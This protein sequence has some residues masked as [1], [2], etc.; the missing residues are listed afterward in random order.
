MK[1]KAF[2]FLL[3]A[4]PLAGV[5]FSSTSVGA[6]P[7][8]VGA[9]TSYIDVASSL[10]SL[11]YESYYMF[12][13]YAEENGTPYMYLMAYNGYGFFARVP[14]LSKSDANHPC[15]ISET[16]FATSCLSAI[17]LAHQ[18]STSGTDF[19]FSFVT[20]IS[21]LY[22][23]PTS[24]E[25][26]G[27]TAS[28]TNVTPSV[29][30]DATTSPET[31]A[32]GGWEYR[33]ANEAATFKGY[34]TSVDSGYATALYV[35]PIAGN[36]IQDKTAVGFAAGLSAGLFTKADAVT[37][38]QGLARKQ[39]ENFAYYIN[40][41]MTHPQ[42]TQ[43]VEKILIDGVTAYKSLL[44]VSDNSGI[45]ASATPGPSVD[46]ATDGFSGLFGDETYTLTYGSTSVQVTPSDGV[47]AFV[48]SLNGL[49]Y[50]CAG[51]DDVTLAVYN[52]PGLGGG[53]LTSTATSALS[54]SARL[55]APSS[56]VSLIEETV[57]PN[58][59]TTS[60]YQD[61]ITP[62]PEEGIQYAIAPTATSM[63]SSEVVYLSWSDFPAFAGLTPETSYTIYKRAH[64]LT[65]SDSFPAYDSANG[66][67]LGQE[68]TTLSELEGEKKSALVA[69]YQKYQEEVL[70]LGDAASATNL[71]TMLTALKSKVE[72]ATSLSDLTSLNSGAAF[73]FALKQDQVVL[74]LAKALAL[75]SGDSDASEASYRDAVAKI[76]ALDY[77]AG[78]DIAGAQTYADG[79]QITISSYRYREKVG[80]SL[81]DFFNASILP[82][83]SRLPSAKQE[84]LWSAFDSAFSQIMATVGADLAATT[85][86][87]DALYASS[88]TSLSDLLTELSA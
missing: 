32:L 40:T 18:Y 85:A 43:A 36:L 23:D 80:K 30:F 39:R 41:Y 25:F 75:N 27:S 31:C 56:G 29:T 38:Y 69:N 44:G 60:L 37:T 22:A 70:A 10:T 88:C 11:T 35:Y 19:C 84:Q 78:A 55:A 72:A 67:Y 68:F 47:V 58:E 48:G 7:L 86:A 66:V 50:D 9:A 83:L 82:G 87:V 57:A 64:S 12:G 73:A 26:T 28:N 49:D 20:Y 2:L 61:K 81:V 74:A 16:D 45:F 79:C 65:T 52:T 17:M 34:G 76:A 71:L 15:G 51:H 1:K 13:A 46:Y 62:L 54:V 6:K 3:A 42:A 24:Y 21:E 77:F 4:L 63:T 8:E 5:V 33:I 53:D 59:N 14:C